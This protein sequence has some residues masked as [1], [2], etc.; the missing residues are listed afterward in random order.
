MGDE[1]AV[2]KF[3]HEFLLKKDVHY[4]AIEYIHMSETTGDVSIKWID[5]EGR[6]RTDLTKYKRNV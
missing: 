1:L 3:I 6:V 2:R 5:R 4:R